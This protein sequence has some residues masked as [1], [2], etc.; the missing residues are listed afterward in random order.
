M[1]RL[2][3]GFGSY[4]RDRRKE[5]LDEG[6]SGFSLRDVARLIGVDAS[7]LSRVEREKV[8]P[9]SEKSIRELAACLREHP[10][11]LLALGGKVPEDVQAIILQRPELFCMAIRRLA[12]VSDDNVR[13]FLDQLPSGSRR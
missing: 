2:V 7:Y 13:W 8:D 12:S 4:I 10:D 1:K 6:E 11:F 5:L 3:M 9:P